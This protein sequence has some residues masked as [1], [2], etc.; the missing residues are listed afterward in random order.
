MERACRIPAGRVSSDF[1][2]NIIPITLNLPIRAVR[3][4]ENRFLARAERKPDDRATCIGG[5]GQNER[6]AQAQVF[7][8]L[9][10]LNRI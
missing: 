10:L 1:L 7:V 3:Y 6:A 9:R 8:G 2:M 5:I 4:V